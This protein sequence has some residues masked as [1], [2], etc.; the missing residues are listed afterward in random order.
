MVAG[1]REGLVVST[2]ERVTFAYE[3]AGLGSRFLAQCIDLLIFLGLAIVL[4]L[5]L[6]LVI[7]L[8]HDANL[9]V[10]G[11]VILSFVLVFGYFPVAEGLTSGQTLGKRVLRL[12]VVGDRGE[13]INVSQAAIRNL[14]R[15]VDFLPIVYGVGVVTIFAGGKGKRLGDYAA[16]TVVVRER[17]RVGLGD[18]LRIAQTP[19]PVVPDGAELPEDNYTRAAARLEGQLRRFVIA[20][21]QRRYYVPPWRRQQLADQVS[22]ALHALMPAEVSYYGSLVVLVALADRVFYTTQ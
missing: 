11:F 8:T 19:A 12:R 14:V 1:E 16:G 3:V 10:I 2:P 21:G 22:N 15:I 9:A 4:L 7:N 18:L 20:Y 17:Q 6:W 5:L 13:P